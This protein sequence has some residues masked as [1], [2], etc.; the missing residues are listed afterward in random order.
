MLADEALPDGG[1]AALEVSWRSGTL[2]VSA[3]GA[4]L[5][6]CR[7][8]ALPRGAIGVAALH[9]TAVFDNLALA[10]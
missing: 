1:L 2:A 8:P 3:G 9:G 10:R 6:H 4:S 7:P 5:L